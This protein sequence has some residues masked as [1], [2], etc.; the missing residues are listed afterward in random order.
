MN[1]STLVA[2][3]PEPTFPEDTLVSLHD[4]VDLGIKGGDLFAYLFGEGGDELIG[5]GL[6]SF[7]R[8]MLANLAPHDHFSANLA[9]HDKALVVVRHICLE[10]VALRRIWGEVVAVRR[11]WLRGMTS[12]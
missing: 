6:R 11:I 1:Q 12:Q 10:V 4:L 7:H 5:T 8:L 9:L 2:P 3:A